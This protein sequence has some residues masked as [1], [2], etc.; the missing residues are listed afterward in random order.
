MGIV[1][2]QRNTRSTQ[3]PSCGFLNSGLPEELV[4]CPVCGLAYRRIEEVERIHSIQHGYPESWLEQTA[5]T[6]AIAPSRPRRRPGRLSR[7]EEIAAD[8]SWLCHL[9]MEECLDAA[10]E[11]IRAVSL[12]STNNT[13]SAEQPRASHVP[14]DDRRSDPGIM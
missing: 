7:E 5:E 1:F 11:A 12:E 2:W 3:C 6:P 13:R 8:V 14:D 10:E 9:S 4:K